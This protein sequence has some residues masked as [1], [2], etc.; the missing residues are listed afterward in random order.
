MSRYLFRKPTIGQQMD[1]IV[2]AVKGD[3][4]AL[5]R[6]LDDLAVVDVLSLPF[7]ELATV[8]KDYA[9]AMQAWDEEDSLPAG[10]ADF[11]EGLLEEEDE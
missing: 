8:A 2:A 6:L 4:P 5:T 11:L 3:M 7:T 9:A 10:I 1:I